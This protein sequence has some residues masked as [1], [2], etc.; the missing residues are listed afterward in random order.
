MKPDQLTPSLEPLDELFL[1]GKDTDELKSFGYEKYLELMHN[2]KVSGAEMKLESVLAAFQNSEKI[3][4]PNI[5][6]MDRSI[7]LASDDALNRFDRKF[8]DKIG[9]VKERLCK[10][11]LPRMQRKPLGIEAETQTGDCDHEKMKDN[12]AKE[13]E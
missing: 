7:P 12:W 3:M 10:K 9:N 6:E 5:S 2:T 13:A 4:V 11:M 1:T 8:S